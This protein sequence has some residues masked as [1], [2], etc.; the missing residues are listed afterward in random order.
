MKA[1]VATTDKLTGAAVEGAKRRQKAYKLFDG[2]GLYLLVRPDGARWWRLKYRVD[3][4]E[5]LISLGTYPARSLKAART[6]RD[7]AKNLL[8]DGVDPSHRRRV[9]RAARRSALENTFEVVAREWYGKK[10]KKWVATHANKVIG[11][12]TRHVFPEIGSVPV[13]ELTGV[14]LGELLSKIEQKAT[15]S[16]AHRCRQYL[17]SVSRYAIQTSRMNS[18]PTPHSETLTP[19][20]SAHYASIT[21]P[22]GVRGLLRSIRGYAGTAVTVAALSLAPLVFVRPGE[23]RAAEWSEFNLE[24]AEWKIPAHR[25]KMGRAHLVPLSKQATIILTDLKRL[26][27]AGRYVFP[28]ERGAGRCMSENTLNAALRSM[29]YSREQ[30]T[31]HGFRHMASTL[32]NES[33]KFHGDVIERQLAH[34]D[35]NSI[36]A[37]YNTAEYLNE[38]REMMQWWANRLDSLA[39]SDNVVNLKSAGVAS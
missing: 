19:V 20:V 21:D 39:A 25:M 22:V 8:A 34:A 28:S 29:G 9:D 14:R 15:V 4:V 23:L 26:T 16:T 6:A 27:G 1:L 37:V 31:S 3:G 24:V 5:K 2:G 11:R 35:R 12:L 33:R 10:S 36:R 18:N 30:M 38:R 32:L 17:D 13:S 7:A